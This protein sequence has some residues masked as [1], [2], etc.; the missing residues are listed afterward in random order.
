MKRL[1]IIGGLGPM[2]TAYFFQL[3]VEMTK[4]GTD[5]EHIEAV[6]YNC[7]SVPDRTQYILGK[8]DVS[9]V[10]S[11]IAVGRQLVENH[12][13]VLA[14]PCVTAH[15]FHKVLEDS[16]GMP[17]IHAVKE[18]AKY[19]QAHGCKKAGIMA[20]DGTVQMK[21]FSKELEQYGI[22]SVYPGTKGQ[23]K[24]MSLIYDCVKAGKPVD[25]SLFRQVSDELFQQGVQVIVLGCTELSMIK[26][27]E[28]VGAGYL[29]VTELLAKCCVESCGTL[30][31][32][33]KEII[34]TEGE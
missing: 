11:L 1:G 25:M 31:D 3:I 28:S 18:T 21:I 32:E 30:K 19:L 4:A 12:V 10:E 23:A 6:I 7:P 15:Y 17:L 13:D 24:V 29:D 8:S 2:A 26:K 16:I 22:E 34:T 5:Q 14:M 9:P 20:T 33:Y 27:S